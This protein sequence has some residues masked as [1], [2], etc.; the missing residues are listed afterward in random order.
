MIRKMLLFKMVGGLDI[1]KKEG[2]EH[3]LQDI[4]MLFSVWIE[5]MK[6]SNWNWNILILIQ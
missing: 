4:R 2:W 6:Y 3:N 5:I 1:E